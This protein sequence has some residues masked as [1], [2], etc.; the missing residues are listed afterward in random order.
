MSPPSWEGS[1]GPPGDTVRIRSPLNTINV[2]FVKMRPWLPQHWSHPSDLPRGQPEWTL[3]GATGEL[4]AQMA[5]GL[6][7]AWEAPL[8]GAP[9]GWGCVRMLL[10]F[11]VFLQVTGRDSAWVAVAWDS[12]LPH[13]PAPAPPPSSAPHAP[14]LQLQDPELQQL[15]LVLRI[16]DVVF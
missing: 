9:R 5:P 7:P 8:S 15:V 12:S 16:L 13:P 2:V 3:T 14:H 11:F 10:L 6:A 4:R 1:A